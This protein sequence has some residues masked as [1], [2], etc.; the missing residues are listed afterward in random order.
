MLGI[1]IFEKP[2][3]TVS[4][5]VRPTEL[6]KRDRHPA[7]TLLPGLQTIF[8]TFTMLWTCSVQK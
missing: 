3:Q 4:R 7:L 8:F 6:E 2:E 5:T 1:S